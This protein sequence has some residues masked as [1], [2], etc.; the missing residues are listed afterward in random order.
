MWCSV[1]LCDMF[2]VSCGVVI[3]VLPL[4]WNVLCCCV[5]VL[6][7][8]IL[9]LQCGVLCDSIAICSMVWCVTTTPCNRFLLLCGALQC[10]VILFQFGVVLPVIDYV[11][12]CGVVWYHSSV[13]WCGTPCN[14][15]PCF[16]LFVASL[17]AKAATT[18][19]GCRSVTSQSRGQSRNFKKKWFF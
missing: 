16:R 10:C 3:L 9:A 6:Q 11:V 19:G 18:L 5:A 12:L 4:Q 15:L 13:V 8:D 17:W 2:A 7:C 1:V 14:R